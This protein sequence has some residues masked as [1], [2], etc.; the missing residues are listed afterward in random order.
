MLFFEKQRKGLLE[1]YG[2]IFFEE[3]HVA[4]FSH[5]FI[6]DASDDEPCVYGD[7]GVSLKHNT[8]VENQSFDNTTDDADNDISVYSFIEVQPVVFIKRMDSKKI[9]L[10]CLFKTFFDEGDDSF[11]AW[12]E[13]SREGVHSSVS[14]VRRTD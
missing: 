5:H 7:T 3:V 10:A 11:N 4:V 8:P 9:L 1:K 14:R 12:W 2:S 6:L 13:R